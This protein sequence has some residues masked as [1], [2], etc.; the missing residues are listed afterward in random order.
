M[1]R[2]ESVG[3][4]WV[5]IPISDLDWDE[6]EDEQ[7]VGDDDDEPGELGEN[8]DNGEYK[9]GQESDYSVKK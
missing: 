4:E 6:E 9:G 2:L 5:K 8:D 3:D 7:E 1:Y